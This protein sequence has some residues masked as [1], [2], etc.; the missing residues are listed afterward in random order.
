MKIAIIGAAGKM[1]RWLIKYYGEQGHKLIASDPNQIGLKTAAETFDVELADDNT[2]TVRN[3]D[4]VV[5]SVPM[6]S[7]VAVVHDIAPHMKKNSILC[8]IS[9]VKVKAFEALSKV[10]SFPIRPLCIH[11]LFG[12]GARTLKRRIALIPL[13]NPEEEKKLVDTIFPESEVIIV[14]A[15]EHDKTMALTIALPYFVNMIVASVLKDE[16][17]NLL[18]RLGGTTFAVQLMLTG[19]IMSNDSALHASLHRENEHVLDILKKFSSRTEQALAHLEDDNGNV[20]EQ[21]YNGIKE[22][23]EE[24]MSLTEKYEEMYRVLEVLDSKS[25]LEAKS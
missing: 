5:V 17:M 2:T 23:L 13:K 1:G 19:S 4:L 22:T 25:S 10:S 9:S 15:D 18:S 12:P 8:E 14:E 3:A 16:D 7:T 24:S 20:F 11:P 6:G 21:A